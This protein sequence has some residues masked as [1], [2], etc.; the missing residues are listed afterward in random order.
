MREHK[1]MAEFDYEGA[2]AKAE[3][4]LTESPP[5]AS[6][7]HREG[8]TWVEVYPLPGQIVRGMKFLFVMCDRD[9]ASVD[10][11]SGQLKHEI[12]DGISGAF[13]AGHDAG[14]RE[15]LEYIKA[16]RDGREE[17]EMCFADGDEILDWVL[18]DIYAQESSQQGDEE[19]LTEILAELKARGV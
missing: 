11:S 5:I 3:A 14:W 13:T 15:Q 19:D 1:R 7:W 18:R 2:E 10:A 16:I 12:G 17:Q 9:V 6:I 4:Y 8:D